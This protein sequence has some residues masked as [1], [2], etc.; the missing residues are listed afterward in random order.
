VIFVTVGLHPQGFDRLLKKM[1]VIANQLDESVIMQIGSSSYHPTHAEWFEYAKNTLEFE[2]YIK[3]ARV[4]VC[5]GGA[6]TII[7]ALRFKKPVI[8][9]P[10]LQKYSEHT[11]DHQVQIVDQFRKVGLIQT[12]LTVDSLCNINQEIVDP[13]FINKREDLIHHLKNYLYDISRELV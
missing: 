9:L 1:D 12:E 6:G 4:V 7:T 5:H 8:A 13:D 11:D 2:S 10:R 3:K